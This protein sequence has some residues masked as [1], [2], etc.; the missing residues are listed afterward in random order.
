MRKKYD[1]VVI[2]SGV[3][4]G[5]IAIKCR[6]AGLTVALADTGPLGGT[7]ALKGCNPKKVLVHASEVIARFKDIE[8]KGIMGHVKI[9]WPELMRFKRTFTESIHISNE[10][11]YRKIGVKLYMGE[12]S[13]LDDKT[14]RI[15]D[16]LIEGKYIVVS[17]G[18]DP[19]NSIFPE[20]NY[21]V[22]V[23]VF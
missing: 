23:N 19:G 17:T 3:A 11:Y 9:D 4:G 14:I 8:G 10:K 16:E 21:F 6:L 22:I 20:K 5:T 13:F 18:A 7:C 2:G 15:G 1:L 12:A